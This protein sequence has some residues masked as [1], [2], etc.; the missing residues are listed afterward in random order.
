MRPGHRIRRLAVRSVAVGGLVLAAL[1]GCTSAAGPVDGGARPTT[2]TGASRLHDGVPYARGRVLDVHVPTGA[3]PST[4]ASAP[5]VVLLHGCCGDRSDLGKLAEALAAARLVVFNADWAGLDADATFPEAYA[6]VVCAIRF[7]RQHT[8]RFGGDPQRMVVAGWSDGAMTI[9]A[10]AASGDT[11]AGDGCL[12]GPQPDAEPLLGVVGISGFYGWT[13]PVG[14]AYVTPRAS[15]LFGGDP[16]TAP[17]GWAAAT[18]Y[19]WLASTPPTLLLVGTTDPLLDDARRYEAALRGAGRQVRLV[20]LPPDG[21]QTLIS[22]RTSEGRL[23]VAEIAALAGAAQP[24]HT[25]PE[26]G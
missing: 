22:P 4:S 5:T 9:A 26:N 24:P 12:A 23:V 11:F 19:M 18:P 16:D 7:A 2:E 17:E 15:R 1:A 10:V 8:G 6:D 20:A 25:S 13:V 3:D 14:P 21:D